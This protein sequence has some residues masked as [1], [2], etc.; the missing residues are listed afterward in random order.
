MENLVC[1]NCRYFRQHYVRVGRNY[2]M[3]TNCGHCVHPKLKDRKPDAR[4]C[5]RFKETAPK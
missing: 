4:A 5:D 1:M 3:E 2:Y